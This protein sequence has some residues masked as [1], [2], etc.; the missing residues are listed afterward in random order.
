LVLKAVANACKAQLRASDLLGRLGGAEFAII[1]P[2]VGREGALPTAEKLRQIIASHS[3][4]AETGPIS[5]TASLG[6]TAV[7]IIGKDLDSL[8]SQADTAT[9]EAK[10]TG[11]NRCEAW[12]RNPETEGGERRRVL[13]SGRIIINDRRSTI[14]CTIRSSGVDGAGIVVANAS[15]IPQ[16]F[17][18]SIDA[19]GFEATCRIISQRRNQIEVSLL[20]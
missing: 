10:Q 1:L 3:I 5:V 9:Y 7:S 12:G 18:L 13:R 15:L 11:R 8:L 6:V 4:G 20:Q 19:D 17:Q 16:R 2:H 14:D